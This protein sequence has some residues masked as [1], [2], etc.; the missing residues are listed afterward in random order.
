MFNDLM[1]NSEI[2]IAAVGLF[3]KDFERKDSVKQ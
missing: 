1:E 3:R 2:P